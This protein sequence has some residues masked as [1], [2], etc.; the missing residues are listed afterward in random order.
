MQTFQRGFSTL[1]M[2]TVELDDLLRSSNR[3]RCTAP[4]DRHFLDLF[5]YK[6]SEKIKLKK[7]RNKTQK[8]VDTNEA[9]VITAAATTTTTIT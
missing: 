4:V 3:R 7:T 9:G 6:K 8:N 1:E 2:P 5:W